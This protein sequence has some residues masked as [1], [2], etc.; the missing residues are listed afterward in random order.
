VLHCPATVGGNPQ[1]LARAERRLGMHSESWTLTQNVY[2][3][4]ADRV[5]CRS[6]GRLAR[7]LMRWRGM[8]ALR[9]ATFDVVHFNFGQSFSPLRV[10]SSRYGSFAPLARWYNNVWA[11][12]WELA[13][14]RWAK[15]RGAV[16]AVTYQGDDARQGDVC[17]RHYRTHFVHHV[18]PEYYEPE[19]DQHKRERIAGFDREADLIYALNPDLL[20]VLP[21]RAQ[22]LPYAS[23]DPAAC[24]PVPPSEFGEPVIVHAPSHRAVKGTSFLVTAL[25]RLRSEGVKFRAI[26]VEGRSNAEALKLYESADLAVDQLLAGFYGALA[27]ELMA[28]GKPVI[29]QL[30]P[31]DLARL[32]ESMRRELPLIHAEPETVYDVLRFWLTEGRSR[33]RAQGAL[34]RAFVERWHDPLTIARR[35]VDDYRNAI[36]ARGHGS[37]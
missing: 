16:V 13:D 12:P 20:R 2:G 35:V 27:V 8:L 15:R 29:C 25:E 22:F 6:G 37:T 21:A 31:D 33:L 10:P 1:G 28:L 32:P 14:V 19:T 36:A 7:A 5:L 17:R 3:Y 34:G 18:P 24:Q 23:V 30:N 9:R 11:G 4:P 26:F